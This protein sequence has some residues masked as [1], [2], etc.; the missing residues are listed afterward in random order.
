MGSVTSMEEIY[1][2]DKKLI[3]VVDVL[4]RE[5]KGLKNQSLF[6]IYD[7]GTVEKRI[8]LE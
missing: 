8:I 2:F 4:G 5:S 3:K 6:Y 1:S 7:D